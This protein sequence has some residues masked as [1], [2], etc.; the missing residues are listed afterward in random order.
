MEARFIMTEELIE[1]QIVDL[2]GSILKPKPIKCTR[3]GKCCV[4]FNRDFDEWRYCR[5]LRWKKS[6]E[7]FCITY[8]TRLG[9]Q[10]GYGYKC[11]YR[12]EVPYNIDGCP[13]NREEWTDHPC[14][15]YDK[16]KSK[17]LNR[18]E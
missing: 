11:G 15:R 1:K 7:T 14:Y 9:K 3:C 2:A 13:Y 10:L 8:K 16:P 4:L 17:S 5:F 18:E 12:R 6:G